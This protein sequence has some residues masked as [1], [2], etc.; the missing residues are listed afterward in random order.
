MTYQNIIHI[1]LQRQSDLHKENETRH[2]SAMKR[3]KVLKKESLVRIRLIPTS[4]SP[5]TNSNLNLENYIAIQ[6]TRMQRLLKHLLIGND[7][8]LMKTSTVRLL[9][10]QL[11]WSAKRCEVWI[12][13]L[14]NLKFTMDKQQSPNVYHG[15]LYSISCDKP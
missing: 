7:L 11:L 8:V 5:S 12:A 1:S 4:F 3:L 13:V 15:E 9:G 10:Q 6:F 2:S 14:S